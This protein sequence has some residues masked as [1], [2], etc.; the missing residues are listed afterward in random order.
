MA[1][2]IKVLARR[3]ETASAAP[4][5]ERI[6]RPSEIPGDQRPYDQQDRI[7]F[8]F[9]TAMVAVWN[10]DHFPFNVERRH[11]IRRYLLNTWGPGYYRVYKWGGTP[12]NDE[13]YKGWT[14]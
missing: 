8:P 14:L 12:P 3:G 2:L 13:Y 5:Q 7:E 10:D 4:I 11:K 6:V 9:P 1:K